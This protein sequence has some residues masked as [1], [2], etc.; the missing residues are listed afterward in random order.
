M[1][2]VPLTDCCNFRNGMSGQWTRTDI[3]GVCCKVLLCGACRVTR[4]THLYLFTGCLRH[5]L[6]KEKFTKLK[7]DFFSERFTEI[8]SGLV[9]M[10]LEKIVGFHNF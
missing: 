10:V 5:V 3:N 9:S 1:S 4:G 7:K 8:N 6:V 2:L